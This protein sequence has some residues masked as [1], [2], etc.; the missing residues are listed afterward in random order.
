[1][2]EPIRLS[3]RVM[4]L[5]NCSR[6][7]A[8]QY[9]MGGWVLV[10]D[11][12]VDAPQFIV[13]KQRIEL[14]PDARL[15]APEP[16]TLLLHKPAGRESDIQSIEAL[17][18][19]ENRWPADDTGITLLRRH[20]TKLT[21]V[22]PLEA[23]A[24]G[25]LVVTQDKAL[26]RRLRE[27]SN[28][29][30]QEFVVEVAG[31][32]AANGLQRLNHGLRFNGRN[33]PPCKVSWQNEIRLRFALSPVQPGQ[34]ASMCADVGLQVVAFKRIRI[35]RVPLAKMSVGEWRYLPSEQRL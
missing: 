35:G 6:R 17:L 11:K 18:A 22:M 27:D 4:E 24:S 26:L 16:A 25:L 14:S 32:I 30:E 31:T 7:E 9:I 21:V 5:A 8:E 33:L 23:E 13:V 28:R 2:S 3:K 29:I 12:V 15:A 20:F 34:I 1:M 19:R 10:D